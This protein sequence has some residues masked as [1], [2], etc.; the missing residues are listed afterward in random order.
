MSRIIFC[1]FSSNSFRYPNTWRQI[2]PD[3]AS[4]DLRELEIVTFENYRKSDTLTLPDI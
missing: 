3:I 1:I 2:E 4:E